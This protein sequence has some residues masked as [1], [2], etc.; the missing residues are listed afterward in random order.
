M[1]LSSSGEWF[2][3]VLRGSPVVWN[4]VV[5]HV[6]R[7]VLLSVVLSGSHA[8]SSSQWFSTLQF[9]MVLHGSQ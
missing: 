2:S 1:V 6:L 7:M 5:L 4:K 8:V 3:V 9:S